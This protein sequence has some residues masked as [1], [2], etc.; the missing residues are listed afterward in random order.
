MDAQ[1]LDLIA[2]LFQQNSITDKTMKNKDSQWRIFTSFCQT[3][4]EQAVP[5]QPDTL[6]R[7]AVYLMVQR[8]CSVPTVRNHLSTIRR[9]HQLFYNVT[10]PSPSQY[11]PLLST[12]KGGAKFLGRNVRQKFPVT[13]EMLT[14]LTLTLP[15]NSPYKSLYNL[16]FFGLPRLGNIVPDSI[17]KFSRIKHLTWRKINFCQD[18]II[19]DLWVTKTIQNFE[20]NLRIPIA[21]APDKPHLCL[22]SGLRLL[23]QIP[24]YPLG[25]DQPV[26]NIYRNGAWFPLTRRD[27]VKF[28]RNHLAFLELDNRS[29]T[30]SG[31]RK[32]GLS[33]GLLCV[34]NLELLRLQGDWL[35]EAYKRYIVIQAEMRFSVSATAISKMPD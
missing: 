18:G 29:I 34:K 19:V 13:A 12:L 22:K 6:V 2:L 11:I 27:V 33:H 32:G 35:S 4:R 17:G 7:Y 30:P 8:R 9:I 1:D 5:V 10:I 21:S 15:P 23:Q 16:L 20:R 26:F 31:F 14:V 3:Y 25:P 28:L 24:G